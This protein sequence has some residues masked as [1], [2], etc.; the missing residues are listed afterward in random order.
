MVLQAFERR[1]AGPQRTQSVLRD[2]GYVGQPFAQ[3]VRE[4]LGEHVIV[5]ITKR[6]ELHRFELVPQR[7]MVERSFAWLEKSRR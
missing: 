5:Q 6:G 1:K 4:V 7:W 2:S 3:A